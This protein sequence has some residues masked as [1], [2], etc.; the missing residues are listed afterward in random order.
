MDLKLLNQNEETHTHKEG[1]WMALCI[2]SIK[3]EKLKCVMMQWN[4]FY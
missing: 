4:V 3:E 1:M 2:D